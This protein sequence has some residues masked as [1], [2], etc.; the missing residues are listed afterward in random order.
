MWNEH[1][2]RQYCLFLNLQFDDH[3]QQV[4][5]HVSHHGG[6]TPPFPFCKDAAIGATPVSFDQWH[7]VAISYDGRMA[8]AWLDGRFD[9]K[10]GHNPFPLPG[11]LHDSGPAG[12][13]FNVGA[14]RRCARMTPE[15][16][17]GDKVGNPFQG[18]LGGLALYNRALD[19]HEILTLSKA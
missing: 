18:L 6:P 2:N 15:G 12:S 3:G 17:V 19:A 4:G 5:A 1:G 8:R 14:V 10:P 16:P 13:D 11:G 9:P 7:C